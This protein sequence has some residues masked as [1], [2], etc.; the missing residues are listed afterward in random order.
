MNLFVSRLKQVFIFLF[1]SL[2]FI[3]VNFAK[4]DSHDELSENLKQSLTKVINENVTEDL[5]KAIVKYVS[6][7]SQNI[8]DDDKT[9]LLQST[10]EM[11]SVSSN[12]NINDFN[13]IYTLL[14][15]LEK[16]I[17]IIYPHILDEMSNQ[18]IPNDLQ[19]NAWLAFDDLETGLVIYDEDIIKRSLKVI[20]KA[21]VADSIT[22]DNQQ[23]AENESE[24]ETTQNNESKK[25][26]YNVDDT[27]DVIGKVQKS[28]K[29][30]FFQDDTQLKKRNKI[31]TNTLLECKQSSTGCQFT[32]DDKTIFYLKSGT[33][34]IINSYYV[35]ADGTQFIKACLLEGGF[36]FKTLRKTNSQVI[37]NIK[38]EGENFYDAIIS[39]GTDAKLGVLKENYNVLDVVNGGATNVSKF[40]FFSE[41]ADTKL[42]NINISNVED[43]QNMFE[44]PITNILPSITNAYGDPCINPNFGNI[45]I[46][47]QE[48]NTSKCTHAHAHNENEPHEDDYDEGKYDLGENCNADIVIPYIICPANW[49]CT[50]GGKDPK[51]DPNV[52]P[53]PNVD[54]GD[55][56]HSG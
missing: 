43:V 8:S 10:K 5:Q 44:T 2:I 50:I 37:I 13:Q 24:T 3:N 38:N 53:D 45:S 49:T 9:T 28:G 20:S 26:N 21:L 19:I 46:K 54:P 4:A 32:L 39:Q 14:N 18:N 16:I 22:E 29:K 48:T 34:I 56:H 6:A 35:D 25:A 36:Y 23:V 17:D 41:N 42:Q 55:D 47:V 30:G 12:G 33:K 40:R 27:N 11:L 31:S 51:K 7:I 1:F 52:N 15:N